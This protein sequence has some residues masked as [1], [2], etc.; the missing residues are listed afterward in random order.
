MPF[1]QSCRTELRIDEQVI[2]TVENGV[3]VEVSTDAQQS[4]ADIVSYAEATI[5][6]TWRDED[7]QS[8][9]QD[10][11]PQA[12]SEYSLASIFMEDPRAEA[13]WPVMRGFVRGVRGSDAGMGTATVHISSPDGLASAIPMSGMYERPS[14]EQV[15]SDAVE[16][17][18]D[19]TPFNATLRGVSNRN[20]DTNS[21]SPAQ[22]VAESSYGVGAFASGADLSDMKSFKANRHSV[23][24][25]CNWVCQN[26]SGRWYFE[27]RSEGT[28]GLSLVYDDGSNAIDFTQRTNKSGPK[29]EQLANRGS[30]PDLGANE[31]D[32]INNSAIKELFPVN[33]V[34]IKGATGAS[35]FGFETAMLPSRKAPF[36]EV[37]YAPLKRRAG[38]QT[39][40]KEYE[41]DNVTLSSSES[42]AK[43]ELRK[44]IQESGMG[45]ITT[46][47]K[48]KIRPYDRLTARPT[49]ASVVENV[50]PLTHQVAS[51]HHDKKASSEYLTHIG[52]SPIFDMS[53]VEITVSEMRDV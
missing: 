25:V 14:I 47:G 42:R 11:D 19:N 8:K 38:G 17:F 15:M 9:I 41:T 24:D 2:P 20:V 22:Y 51:V 34:R 50:N 52:V 6:L 44:Q 10:F 48:P 23:A 7:I 29:E 45:E 39:V 21:T 13:W 1:G 36:V 40:A 32:V 53:K 30:F 26:S 37:E 4:G 18:N 46:Y 35:I 27:F 5:P 28:R 31:V 33:T 16:T 12:Q 3:Q 49:C 43:T